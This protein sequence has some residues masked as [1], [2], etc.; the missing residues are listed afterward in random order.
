MISNKFDFKQCQVSISCEFQ[1]QSALG[2]LGDIDMVNQV[3]KGI[4]PVVV[5]EIQ[6][7]YKE[8]DKNER[9]TLSVRDKENSFR[10]SIVNPTQLQY[11]NDTLED[12]KFITKLD[13]VIKEYGSNSQIFQINNNDFFRCSSKSYCWINQTQ[14]KV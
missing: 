14:T 1:S 12:Q 3:E 10:S 2:R 13:G 7:Q 6:K 9:S 5:Q 8:K 4:S 11:H